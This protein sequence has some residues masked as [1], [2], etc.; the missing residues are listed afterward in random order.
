[1]NW[2]NSFTLIMRSNITTLRDKFEDPERMLHQ[3]IIEMDEE[4]VSVRES[5]A[6]AIADE[7][8][9]GKKV[10]QAREESKQWME[11][12][13][14]S[15]RRGDETAAQAALEQKGLAEERAERLEQEFAKQKQQ[16]VKLQQAVR[17]L[18]DKI[19]QA[20][21]KQTLLLARLA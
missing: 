15:L 17:D 1:M 8:L 18:E 21:Q 19:R 4:L 12:A 9:L 3:L 20:R 11:R 6:G 5:V 14:S 16:T 13:T 10:T 2:L 7:I